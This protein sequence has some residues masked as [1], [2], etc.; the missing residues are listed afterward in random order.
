MS[1]KRRPIMPHRVAVK[2]A[3]RA[4]ARDILRTQP[5]RSRRCRC[6][7]RRAIYLSL[8]QGPTSTSS[9]A[10][11]GTRR[12][13][14]RPTPARTWATRATT[15][16][17]RATRRPSRTWSTRSTFPKF[18]ADLLKAVFDANLKVMKKQTDTYIKLMKEATK[19]TADFI[20]KVKDDETLRAGSP[21]RKSDKYNVTHGKGAGRQPEARADQSRQGDKVDLEDAEVK[22]RHPRGE[23]Q[24]GQGAP[25]G[26]ARGAADGRH[27]PGRGKGRDR[28]RRRLQRSRPRATSKAHHEDQNINVDHHRARLSKRPLGGLFGGPSGSMSMT[29]HQ[30]PGQHVGQEGDRR[31]QRHAARQG[32]HPVQDRLLQARQLREHVR[33]RRNVR[34]SSRRHG[35]P[36]PA[37]RSGPAGGALGH[38]ADG[39]RA[40]GPRRTS[41]RRRRRLRIDTGT[42]RY[43]QLKL[44]TATYA[45]GAG[46]DW[47][48]DVVYPTPRAANP[49]GGDLLRLRDGGRRCRSA[50]LLHR[51]R[52]V[53]AA[54]SRY[55]TSRP[56][57]DSA[58]PGPSRLIDDDHARRCSSDAVHRSTAAVT[59]GAMT[60]FCPA[61]DRR[62]TQC[63]RAVQRS[64]A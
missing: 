27:A 62:R 6:P 8:V 60:P 18:V 55:R 31:P 28:G 50:A 22:Q 58:S 17:S 26:A 45:P 57:G 5:G 34:R 44:G 23:D 56:A 21:R 46:F 39:A 49:R 33:R 51:R 41:T 38:D 64:R 24:H 13:R 19:S 11:Y 15:R 10:T 47:I 14:W 48:D 59:D 54:A 1:C 25:R 43:Y 52:A 29:Q 16:R 4:Q 12:S 32:Q 2:H 9:A 61:A 35:G 30:H 7:S 42:N 53:R 63:R 36:A 37:A 20:K 3:A 40:P